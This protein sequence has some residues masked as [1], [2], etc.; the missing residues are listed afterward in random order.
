MTIDKTDWSL[1][2]GPSSYVGHWS[3]IIRWSLVIGPWSL[4]KRI[5]SFHWSLVIGL[6]SLVF[7]LW[8]LVLLELRTEFQIQSPGAEIIRNRILRKKDRLHPRPT[9]LIPYIQ[10]VEDLQAQPTV[11][12]H[13]EKMMRM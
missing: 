4:V 12:C 6:W 9:R 5:S 1:V 2:I 10:E 11:P 8:S 13:F 3:F 7:G